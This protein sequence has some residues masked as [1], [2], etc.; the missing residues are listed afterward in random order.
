MPT[1]RIERPRPAA[2]RLLD[3][4]RNAIQAR[5]YSPRTAEA[6]VFWTRRFIVFHGKRHP[7]DM[8]AVEVKAF[9]TDLA[10]SHNVAA[11]TQNQALGALIFLYRHVLGRN[12]S[13]P[14]DLIRAK[15]PT[16]VPVVLSQ[17]EIVRILRHL[18]GLPFLAAMLMYGSGLRLLECL[19]LRVQDIDLERAE[20]MVRQG[21]GAKDRR[22]IVPARAIDLLK[23]HFAVLK[24]LHARH[25]KNGQAAVPAPR[26]GR[27][28]RTVQATTA[29]ESQWVFP[30]SRPKISSN[31]ARIRHHL[32]RTAVQRPFFL[33]VRTAGIAKQA[34]C[35]SLRHSFATHLLESSHDIRTIQELLG[36]KDVST[37][38]IYTHPLNRRTQEIR[39]PLDAFP[40]DIPDP[41][42]RWLWN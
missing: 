21:K 27:A 32:H 13:A 24:K 36:H 34:S 31:G 41:H 40:V 37:T 28:E 25:V 15:R 38:M 17:G 42:T 30:A 7:S 4:L 12:L 3:R 11:S 26:V 10:I 29:W 5:N 35:H 8:G 19:Q 18:R 14:A 2:P 20:I 1:N 6:Y 9:L 16:R 22:T 39:S 23:A 33:A